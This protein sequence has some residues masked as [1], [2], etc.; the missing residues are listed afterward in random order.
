MV[1][2]PAQL[3][4]L[5]EFLRRPE[6]KPASEY[7]DGQVIQ[8]PMSQGQHSRLQ[9]KLM[10]TI[11]A[12]TEDAQIALALPEL[13]CT[14]G[15]RSIVPDIAVFQWGRLPVNEDGSIA[16]SF[17]AQPNWTIEILSPD[18]SSTRVISNILHCLEHGCRLG[19]LIDPGERLVQIYHPEQRPLSLEL[20][21]DHLPTPTFA[22]ALQLDLATLFGWLRLR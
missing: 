16:N 12:V 5:K 15:G 4:T 11:N 17:N 7:A 20:P 14:F 22:P 18:Q 1:Q 10:S 21:E 19:W 3:I 6:T 9:Q 8:K 13:R 2:T